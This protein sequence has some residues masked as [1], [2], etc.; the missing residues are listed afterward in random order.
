MNIWNKTQ[1][2]SKREKRIRGDMYKCTVKLVKDL[3]SLKAKKKEASLSNV[4]DLYIFEHE[5]TFII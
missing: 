2:T 5:K 4:K 1:S 3:E